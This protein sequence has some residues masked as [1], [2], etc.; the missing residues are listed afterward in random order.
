MNCNA[1]EAVFR[2]VE[3]MNLAHEAKIFMRQK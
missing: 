2:A 3:F 1:T